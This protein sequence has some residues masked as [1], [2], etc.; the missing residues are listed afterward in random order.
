VSYRWR[1]CDVCTE[2]KTAARRCDGRPPLDARGLCQTV[3]VVVVVVFVV[4]ESLLTASA[5][6]TIRNELLCNALARRRLG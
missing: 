3:V 5:C 4:V 1:H 6:N 2:Q